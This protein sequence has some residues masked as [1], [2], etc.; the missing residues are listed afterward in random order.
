MVAFHS[1]ILFSSLKRSSV[2]NI[3]D[4]RNL[5]SPSPDRKDFRAIGFDS[6]SLK[7]NTK[8]STSSD[9]SLGPDKSLPAGDS[10]AWKDNGLDKDLRAIK[11]STRIAIPACFTTTQFRIKSSVTLQNQRMDVTKRT[12]VSRKIL[13]DGQIHLCQRYE[14]DSMFAKHSLF[15][16]DL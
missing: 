11:V 6:S 10:F 12:T 13:Q 2:K 1:F 16:E 4:L 5:P 14:R 15:E 7:R 8:R 3:F 9:G